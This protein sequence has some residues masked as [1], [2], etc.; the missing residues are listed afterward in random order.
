MNTGGRGLIRRFVASAIGAV[1]VVG[2]ALAGPAPA[3]A[4]DPTLAVSVEITGLAVSGSKPSDTVTIDATVTNTGTVDAYGVQ[5]RMWRARDPIQD[6]PTLQAAPQTTS[7]WGSLVPATGQTFDVITLSTVP[8]PPGAAH[9]VTLRA[10]L[11][12]LGFDTTGA[13][14]AVGVRVL[15][16]D[17][18]SSRY[19]LIGQARAFAAV[20]GKKKV[21]VTP[22][23]LLSAPPTKL[24][25]GLFA[26]DSLAGELAGRLDDLLTAAEN[27]Q[28]S[29]LVDPALLDEVSDMAD[30]YTILGP[31]TAPGNDRPG[32]G[33]QAAA[34]W[35][36]RFDALPPQEGARTLFAN[37]DPA[38]DPASLSRALDAQAASG[39]A[40]GLPLIVVPPGL[41][42]TKKLVAS[43]ADAKPEAVVA[44]N[45][46]HAG[47]VQSTATTALALS[48]TVFGGGATPPVTGDLLAEAA[49]AGESG[50]VRLIVDAAGLAQSTQATAPWMRR[51][52]LAGLL[53][54]EP[55]AKASYA[56]AKATGLSKQQRGDV[57]RAAHDLNL[58]GQVVSTF[59]LAGDPSALLTRLS[60]CEWIAAPAAQRTYRTAVTRLADTRA[61]RDSVTLNVSP[62]VVMSSQHNVFPVTVTNALATP[63]SVTI[64]TTTN[65]PRI[66]VPAS[67]VTEIPPGASQTI[68]LSPQ[69]TDNGIATAEIHIA[70]PQGLRI[71]ADSAVTIEVT[72]LGIIGWIIV[73]CS[74]VVLVGATWFRIQ[75]VAHGAVPHAVPAED[76]EDES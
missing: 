62:R 44:V 68:V 75:Q 63:V 59:A 58:Y 71:T 41:V 45:L 5:V 29:Y 10:T 53:D 20:P 24:A 39:Q 60:S 4:A 16:T 2:G 47:S 65:N 72:N 55:M 25:A 35:L 21:P 57:S 49:A 50:Q 14:Y 6:L 56:D 51:L 54:T 40:S 30:G 70:S 74:A 33:Q 28:A 17:D 37:P 46:S 12:Q 52:S 22:V 36:A 1:L 67:D 42:A 69:A 32:A 66:S 61:L 18:A 48:V 31:G 34:A 26:D 13:A 7:G 64:A 19:T 23:V 15:G 27:G 43:L 38:A 8:F 9:N 73:G 11:A 3:R 76:E